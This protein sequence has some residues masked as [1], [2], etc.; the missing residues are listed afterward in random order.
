MIITTVV[1]I[2]WKDFKANVIDWVKF[3]AVTVP[4]D[5]FKDFKME[6]AQDNFWSYVAVIVTTIIIGVLFP[7]IYFVGSL[8]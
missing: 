4:V 3:L 6:Y 1:P 8:I 7:I 5:L 2:L